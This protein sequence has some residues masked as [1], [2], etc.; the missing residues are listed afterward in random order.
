MCW[1]VAL[2]H[3]HDVEAV[4]EAGGGVVVA[5]GDGI[6]AA[7]TRTDSKHA[8]KCM[9][10]LEASGGQNACQQCTQAVTPISMPGP[11]RRSIQTPKEA[12]L[13]GRMLL[14][15]SPPA[16]RGCRRKVEDEDHALEVIVHR[17]PHRVAFG[18]AEVLRR[19]VRVCTCVCE[20]LQIHR[21]GYSH[22][23]LKAE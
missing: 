14:F 12:L 17:E 3:L 8:V 5:V 10:H 9:A 16:E 18:R 6:G 15:H 7:H 22:T 1:A 19:A 11:C 20:A 23:H 4:V 2:T 21:Q 13:H